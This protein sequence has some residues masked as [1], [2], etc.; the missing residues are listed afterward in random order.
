MIRR[1]PRSTR[2][3]TLFPYTT[4]F[5]SPVRQGGRRRPA[6]SIRQRRSGQTTFRRRREHGGAR[7]R[8]GHRRP[9]CLW[10]GEGRKADTNSRANRTDRGQRERDGY[11][12]TENDRPHIQGSREV[13]G[14]R[15]REEGREKR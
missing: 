7:S 6:G 14:G 9:A 11:G 10:N 4:L 12:T 13:E 1:P 8:A 5:R 15:V 2:T 3:D